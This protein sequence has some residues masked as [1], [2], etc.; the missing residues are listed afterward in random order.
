MV[1]QLFQFDECLLTKWNE[2]RCEEVKESIDVVLSNSHDKLYLP[3][4]I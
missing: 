3:Y 2:E 1:V 4:A